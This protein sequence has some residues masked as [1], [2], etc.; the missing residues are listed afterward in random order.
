MSSKVSEHCAEKESEAAFVL[1]GK[2]CHDPLVMSA[3][4]RGVNC[5]YRLSL[6]YNL[7]VEKDVLFKTRGRKRSFIPYSV[8]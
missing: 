7:Y 2:E 4:G 3:V 6:P 5:E 1:S 8:M